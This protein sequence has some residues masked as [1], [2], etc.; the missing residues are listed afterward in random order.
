MSETGSTL[1]SGY[2]L[3]KYE[4]LT[5][6]DDFMFCKIMTTHPRLCKHLLELILQV[7][8]KDI[9]FAEAQ[10]VIEMTADSRGIRLDVYVNDE[11]GTVYDIEM[12]TTS[13]PNLPKRSR[14]YQGMIDLNAL[15]KG[16]DY[17]NLPTTFVIFICTF[18]LFQKNLPIYT[19]SNRCHECEN[20]ELGDETQKLFLNPYCDKENLSADLTAFFEYLL[21]HFSDNRFV[22]ELDHAVED[23]RQHREWR[24]EYMTLQMKMQEQYLKGKEDEKKIGEKR[25]EKKLITKVCKKIAKNLTLADIADAL[26]ES[27]E[28]IEPIYQIAME[29]S[30]EF[31]VDAIYEKL[32]P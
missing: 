5:I 4:D 29:Q 22:S 16:V 32:H 24:H 21:G 7:E 2:Q 8:I 3:K 14:Y 20:L 11:K 28:L 27:P 9:R 12:Q 23:A 17:T 19:F 30:P 26:E 31:D 13:N 10:K 15:E 1:A 6:A 18:D 25:E